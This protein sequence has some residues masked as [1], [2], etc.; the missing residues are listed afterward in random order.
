MRILVALNGSPS[1]I[2]MVREAAQLARN[3]WADVTLLGITPV[4]SSPPNHNGGEP[5]K[6]FRQVMEGFLHDFLEMVNDSES[7][8]PQSLTE[9]KW[10]DADKG[11]WDLDC[12]QPAPG[13]KQ[14]TLR[15]RAGNAAKIILGHAQVLES[16]IIVIG[17]GKGVGCTWDGSLEV[18]RTIVNNASC[19]VFAVKEEKQPR[20][21]VCCLDNDNVSQASLELVNQLVTIY[22]A[23]LGLVGVTG[24]E[25]L[26][27][28]VDRKMGQLLDYYA[29]SDIRAWV[30]LVEASSLESFIAQAAQKDL[31]ALWMGKQS[32]L[33]K[34]F[35]RQRL[36]K[37]IETA[38]S[39]VLI[40]R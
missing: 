23:E 11:A 10:K 29:G 32:F 37:L 12:Q 15:M 36:G 2:H 13:K 31:V 16:D 3:T 38:Q 8:Y 30:Q 24:A 35:F 5:P 6:G 17:C 33:D 1:S 26:K 28:E 19:S 40:L 25:G 20:M 9:Y 22:H 21:V 27:E 7:P 39:S 4:D 34:I 14:L 18:P